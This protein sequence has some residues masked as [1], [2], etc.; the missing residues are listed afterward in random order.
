MKKLLR[1]LLP[2]FAFTV[3]F[4]C[5]AMADVAVAPMYVLFI[6]LPVLLLIVAVIIVAVIV[7]ALRSNK[8]SEE[9]GKDDD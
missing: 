9:K 1:F 6:G 7:K 2:F 5:T 8:R 4:M 3:C